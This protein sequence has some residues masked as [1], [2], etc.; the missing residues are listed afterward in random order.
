MADEKIRKVK[1]IVVVY[2]SSHLI[3]TNAWLLMGV[4][5]NSVFDT[6]QQDI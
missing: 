2:A 4:F 1:W 3:G 5:V 6:E